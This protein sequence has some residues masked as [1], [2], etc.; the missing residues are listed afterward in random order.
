MTITHHSNNQFQL[1][2]TLTYKNA[3]NAVKAGR[4]A[5]DLESQA[6]ISFNLSHLEIV[7][8]SAIAVLIDWKKYCN[9]KSNKTIVFTGVSEQLKNLAM[10][11]GVYELLF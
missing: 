3:M 7:D 9:K 1:P 10:V 5:I 11:Y 8:S 2:N 4:Q 6:Q